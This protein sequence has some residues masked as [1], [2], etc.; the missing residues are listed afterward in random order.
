M[1]KLLKTVILTNNFEK[2]FIK[3]II[4]IKRRREK[5]PVRSVFQKQLAIK[6]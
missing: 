1:K 4:K 2:Y 5:W 6:K 3:K